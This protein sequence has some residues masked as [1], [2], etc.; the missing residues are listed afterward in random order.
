VNW[1]E[2]FI[3]LSLSQRFRVVTTHRLNRVIFQP[4][5]NGGSIEG[6]LSPEDNASLLP[7]ILVAQ[8]EISKTAA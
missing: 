2:Y 1:L 3:S 6:F 7:N 5:E 4:V 8:R